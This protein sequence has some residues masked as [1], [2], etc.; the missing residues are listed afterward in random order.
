[1]NGLTVERVKRKYGIQFNEDAKKL[2][3]DFMSDD[4]LTAL[5]AFCEHHLIE[6]EHEGLSILSDGVQ[7]F[8]SE[9]GPT[10]ADD[11]KPEQ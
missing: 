2:I 9:C 5:K 10:S 3:D 4:P 11:I 8:Y 6:L 7:V 1:M